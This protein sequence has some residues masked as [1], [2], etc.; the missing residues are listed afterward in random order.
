MANGSEHDRSWHKPFVHHA[1]E[2]ETYLARDDFTVFGPRLL[3]LQHYNMRQ[4]PSKVK[5]LWR[6]RRNPLQW[7]TFWAV[8]WIGGASIVLAVLQL[9]VGVAQV[10]FAA[11]PLPEDG[12]S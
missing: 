12:E 5:D 9:L 1:D 4:Q 6:D 11:R 8:L 7:Y 2:S 10:Y 3:R